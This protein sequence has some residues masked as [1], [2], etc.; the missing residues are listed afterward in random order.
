MHHLGYGVGRD[1]RVEGV[2][3]TVGFDVGG[4]HASAHVGVQAGV[5]ELGEEGVG[6]CGWGGDV[7]GAGEGG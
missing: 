3:W 2:W 7:E 6:V 4:A 1:G 5:E